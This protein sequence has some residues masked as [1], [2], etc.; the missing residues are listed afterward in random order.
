[1]IV[2]EIRGRPLGSPDVLRSK[3]LFRRAAGRAWRADASDDARYV[4]ILTAW[5]RAARANSKRRHGLCEEKALC[6]IEAHLAYSNKI[7]NGFHALG[8]R[9]RAAAVSKF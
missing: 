1:M 6:Q 5:P 3:E 4:E 2:S 8:D 9:S 7:C